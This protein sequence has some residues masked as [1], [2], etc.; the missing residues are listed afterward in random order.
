MSEEHLATEDTEKIPNSNIQTLKEFESR[1][2]FSKKKLL[3]Y[4]EFRG[5]ELVWD[6]KPGAWNFFINLCVLCALCG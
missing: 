4:L 5:L 2:S 3:G 6:L 1:F